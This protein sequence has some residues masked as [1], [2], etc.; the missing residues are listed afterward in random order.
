MRPLLGH[1]HLELGEL[2]FRG[3]EGE[4]AR[5]ETRAALSIYRE[6]SMPYWAQRAERQ[7]AWE[8]TP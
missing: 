1:C 3:G 2:A 7:L 6:L 4:R 8:I 5:G